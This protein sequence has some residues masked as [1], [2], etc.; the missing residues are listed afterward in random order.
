M[1]V[2]TNY[3]N[4]NNRIVLFFKSTFIV[5]KRGE[6]RLV[7]NKSGV[8]VLTF[9]FLNMIQIEHKLFLF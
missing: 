5:V 7:E 1:F 8:F 4:L 6:R 3:F 2:L 9:R